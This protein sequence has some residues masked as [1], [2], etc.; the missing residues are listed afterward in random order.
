MT[1]IGL[2]PVWKAGYNSGNEANRGRRRFS[3]ISIRM[4][5]MHPAADVIGRHAA[6]LLCIARPPA[7]SR[8]FGD[9]NAVTLR[10]PH[11]AANLSKTTDALLTAVFR[12]GLA[13]RRRRRKGVAG[14]LKTIKQ[15]MK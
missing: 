2:S 12:R 3:S 4:K 7:P 13:A 8:G 9:E 15:F 14:R 5:R 11:D 1:K 6:E 10:F